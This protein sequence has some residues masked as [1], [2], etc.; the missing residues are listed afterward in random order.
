M[1]E[2]FTQEHFVQLLRTL[3]DAHLI[4]IVHRDLRPANIMRDKNDWNA[5]AKANVAA[6]FR[7]S[8]RTAS[9]R[10]LEE[11]ERDPEHVIFTASDDMVSAVKTAYLLSH[12]HIN[13]RLCV[14]SSDDF[15]GLN[16]FWTTCLAGVWQSAVALASEGRFAELSVHFLC[17]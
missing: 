13:A 15:G 4:G 7:G 2:P 10:V 16:T 17:L 12:P 9:S 14:I 1:V 8:T 6:P 11:L 3:A 5:A